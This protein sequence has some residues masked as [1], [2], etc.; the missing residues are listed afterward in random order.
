MKNFTYQMSVIYLLEMVEE[1]EL[2][3]TQIIMTLLVSITFKKH[4][5]RM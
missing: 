3:V 1:Q 2:V 5:M 4:T